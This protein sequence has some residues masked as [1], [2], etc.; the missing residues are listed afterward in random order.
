[1]YA[2]SRTGT[3][4]KV[5]IE[6]FA[7]QVTEEERLLASIDVLVRRMLKPNRIG[8][9]EAFVEGV[10]GARPIFAAVE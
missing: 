6:R 9:Q 1:M 3:E 5:K 10:V 4:S 2:L 8:Q 7:E